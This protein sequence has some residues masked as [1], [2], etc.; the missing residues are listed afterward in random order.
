MG[1]SDGCARIPRGAQ[2]QHTRRMSQDLVEAP[3]VP[4]LRRGRSTL[5]VLALGAVSWACELGYGVRDPEP[6][7]P[8]ADAPKTVRTVRR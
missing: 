4:R 5:F 6:V 1:D 2:R 7:Q 3:A 8:D